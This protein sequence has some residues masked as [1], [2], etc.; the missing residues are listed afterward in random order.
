MVSMCSLSLAWAFSMDC[1][2]ASRLRS[3][4]SMAANGFSSF[5]PRLL[6]R[7][8]MAGS[9]FSTSV[10]HS[11][12]R[13]ST[14]WMMAAAALRSTASCL[15]LRSSSMHSFILF[16]DSATFFFICEWLYCTLLTR[17]LIF[18][19]SAFVS[20]RGPERT[21]FSSSD[22]CSMYLEASLAASAHSCRARS[23]FFCMAACGEY[24]SKYTVPWLPAKVMKPS[25][26]SFS[27]LHFM[28]IRPMPS[29]FVG[30]PSDSTTSPT[31]SLR[32]VL[33][34]F[35]VMLSVME[36]TAVHM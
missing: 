10:L 21:D 20:D 23:I 30:S 6:T 11:A 36:T 2:R 19:S 8:S 25:L 4:P 7:V 3:A 5:S 12:K 14:S 26:S 28:R 32:T 22:F 9:V 29:S 17:G 31:S 35:T 34:P 13:P 27:A 15:R 16:S 18:R 24:V 1:T 33:P